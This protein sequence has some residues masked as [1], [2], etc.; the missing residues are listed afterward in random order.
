MF[1]WNYRRALLYVMKIGS[2]QSR[3]IVAMSTALFMWIAWGLRVWRKKIIKDYNLANKKQLLIITDKA[4]LQDVKNSI[5]DH[6][7]VGYNIKQIISLDKVD[8][9]NVVVM[10]Y[11]EQ[12]VDWAVRQWI[13]EC[14][15]CIEG[16]YASIVDIIEKFIE[17]GITSQYELYK[18][19]E[20]YTN[21]VTHVGKYTTL[22]R[23]VKI[24]NYRDAFLKRCLDIVG[25]LV[26]CFIT[27]ILMCTF[28]LAIKIKDPGPVFFSQTRIGQNGK[29][30]KIYKFRSMYMDAEDRKKKLLKQNTYGEE[31]LMFKLDDDPRIIKGI[32]HFIRDYSI[33]E[34]PQ[35]FC[36]LLGTMSL[37]GTR[38]PLVD[39][40]EKY[41]HHHRIR[42][43]VKPGITGM[44]QVSGRNDITDFEEVVKL[45]RQYLDNWSIGQDIK[46]LFKTVEVVLKKEGSK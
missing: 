4:N 24:A 39:E 25:G 16:N 7:F 8:D 35:F 37:V 34:F 27:L 26:G 1:P 11:H 12:I 3:L 40:W 42:M 29:K 10:R 46:I 19:Q 30:F 41:S 28:G 21:T 17:M 32:G 43:A 31:S 23:T 45:D 14:L 22:T 9:E 36:V 33:D 20:R 5:K 13:D 2:Y 6:E 38:P 18:R 44:W 15:F